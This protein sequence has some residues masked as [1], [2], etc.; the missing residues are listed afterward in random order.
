MNLD[1]MNL[2]ANNLKN[3]NSIQ[4]KIMISIVLLII[5][6][7]YFYKKKADNDY[8]KLN[9]RFHTVPKYAKDHDTIPGHELSK[10]SSGYDFTYFMWL[11]IDNMAYKYK[12]WKHII[13]K[14][15]SGFT[16]PKCPGFWIDPV[17]NDIV[18]Q[19][20]TQKGLDD[21]KIKDFPLKK[22]F[23]IGIVVKNTEL[24]L[25]KN[26]K[27]EKFLTL[28]SVPVLNTGDLEINKY[29]G[30]DGYVSNIMYFPSSKSHI[31]MKIIHRNGVNGQNI[32]EKAYNY[33][34][35]DFKSPIEVDLGLMKNLNK[36]KNNI[37]K[38]G[39][40]YRIKERIVKLGPYTHKKPFS[41]SKELGHVFKM[42]TY[43]IRL[44]SNNK[45]FELFL[46][47]VKDG[48]EQDIILHNYTREKSKYM[49][50]S[51]MDQYLTKNTFS[52]AS[53]NVMGIMFALMFIQNGNHPKEFLK[54]LYIPYILKVVPNGKEHKFK[55]ELPPLNKIKIN[56]LETNMTNKWYK[57]MQ[58]NKIAFNVLAN[59]LKLNVKV[60]NKMLTL[61]QFIEKFK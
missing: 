34:F 40:I 17:L 18:I 47:Q 48:L 54:N 56:G 12:Q 11:Y 44:N 35:A 30:F 6:I 2:L 21:F 33:F 57:N 52:R 29:G 50:L 22:W 20:Q 23:S 61:T 36:F 4:F 43:E 39:R 15:H 58:R 32:F 14:G 25:Y 42:R 27:I 7:L 49:S 5:I 28:K 3:P 46:S 51:N 8:R 9:P 55:C 19:I 38:T 24:E 26:G 41:K 60:E 37:S 10:S 13:T 45:R 53:Y 31:F 1:K 59:S 16:K